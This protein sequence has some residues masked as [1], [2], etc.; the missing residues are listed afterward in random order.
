MFRRGTWFNGI[1][2]VCASSFFF[3]TAVPVFIHFFCAR[4]FERT[5]DAEA[6]EL[7]VGQIPDRLRQLRVL[8]FPVGD[9]V[10]ASGATEAVGV[11][12]PG[13]AASDVRIG[14]RGDVPGFGGD[15]AGE[16][17]VVIGIVLIEA[18]FGDVAVHVV[19]A[20]GVGLFLADFLIL[21]IAVVAEP[22]VFAEFRGVITEGVSG[23]RSGAAG[24][25]PLG[26]GRQAIEVAGLCAEPLAIFVGGM[27]RHADGG[28]A[29]FAHSEA[30]FWTYGLVGR[31][32]ASATS[33]SVIIS[34][35]VG[36]V[37]LV[38]VG[39]HPEFVFVP[40]DFVLF[41][42]ERFDFN[43]VLRMFVGLALRFGFG[44]AHRVFAARDREHGVANGRIGNRVRVRLHF[45]CGFFGADGDDLGADCFN[46]LHFRILFALW[47]FC[48]LVGPAAQGGNVFGSER[49][50]VGKNWQDVVSE[51][52]QS[53]Q[54]VISA[55]VLRLRI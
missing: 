44:T 46:P 52:D 36:A 43:F 15:F 33:P 13:T 48:A 54:R 25:F 27:L 21:Q 7:G 31:A 12:G 55:L 11:V 45:G 35:A 9:G 20:P 2:F 53:H 50:A 28:I 41:H 22:R 32:T 40:G 14:F 47:P 26:F 4:D 42:P 37:R 18:P 8:H 19:E 49:A 17:F 38:F 3:Y 6:N 39:I 10:G 51:I 5:D 23:G 29:I 34:G 16:L 30:H 1:K 24:V